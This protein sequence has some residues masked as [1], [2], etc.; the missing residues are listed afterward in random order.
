[1]AEFRLLLEGGKLRETT[2]S[3]RP[4]LF[5]WIPQLLPYFYGS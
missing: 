4:V 2:F 1:M 5:S 3:L